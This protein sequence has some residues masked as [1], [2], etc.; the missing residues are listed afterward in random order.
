MLRAFGT[1]SCSA[2]VLLRNGALAACAVKKLA[3]SK[4]YEKTKANAELAGLRDAEGSAYLA[5]CYGAFEGWCPK[6]KKQCLW[7]VME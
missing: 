2:E 4:G 7:I 1:C 3:Y 5:Q 6:A